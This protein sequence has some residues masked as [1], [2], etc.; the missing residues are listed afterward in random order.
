MDCGYPVI[1]DATFLKR[2]H[3]SRFMS[4]ATE[5]GQPFLILCMRAPQEVLESRVAARSAAA[6]DASEATV[7]VLAAQ[8]E[9]LEPLGDE[10]RETMLEI[11]GA[12]EVDCEALARRILARR[13]AP[14]AR[15]LDSGPVVGP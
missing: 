15:R 3:R 4:L 5:L 9:E 6:V 13:S 8:L 14:L 1:V 2:E 10:E 7:E 11:D 12:A